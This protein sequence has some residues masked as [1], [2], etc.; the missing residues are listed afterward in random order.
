MEGS[1]SA[2]DFDLLE[3]WSAGDG[4]AG[5]ELFRRHALGV[6]RFFRSKVPDAAEDLTQRTLLAC[7]EGRDRFRKA[8]SFRT[9]LFG[10]AR[11]QLLMHLRTKR[12]VEAR[13]EPSSVSIVDTGAGP[14]H[15][16]AKREEQRVVMEALRRVPIDFQITL[17]LFYWEEMSLVEIAEVLGIAKGTV[18]SRLARGREM[19]REQ[20]ASMVA[21]HQLLESSVNDLEKWTRSLGKLV[22]HRDGTGGS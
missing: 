20:L 15:L 14:L 7:V 18:K 5:D 3:A 12:A 8:A 10:I 21:S 9:Y 19:L 6:L 16:A 2:E 11:N 1:T 4:R 13:F 17:E 22:A